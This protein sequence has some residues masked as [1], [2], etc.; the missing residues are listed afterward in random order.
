MRGKREEERELHIT[1][2]TRDVQ[3]IQVQGGKPR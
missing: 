1:K 3:K 2:C